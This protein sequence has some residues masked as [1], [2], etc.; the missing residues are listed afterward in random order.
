[1]LIEREIVVQQTYN[2]SSYMDYFTIQ[3]QLFCAW[4]RGLIDF[5]VLPVPGL[6]KRGE[7]AVGGARGKVCGGWHHAN[8]K[9]DNTKFFLSRYPV[10]WSIIGRDASFVISNIII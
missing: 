6:G 4:L 10:Q 5:S 2:R 1:M 7:V 8:E 3:Q 9:P